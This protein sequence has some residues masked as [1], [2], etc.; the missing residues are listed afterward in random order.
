MRHI[1]LSSVICLAVPY[2]STFLIKGTIFVKKYIGHNVC[3]IFCTK[4]ASNISYYKNNSSRY[5]M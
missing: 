1:I 4:F 3:F 5:H 2:I